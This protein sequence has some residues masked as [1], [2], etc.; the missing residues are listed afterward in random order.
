M[1]KIVVIAGAL[2]A[3]GLM[4]CTASG[5]NIQSEYIGEQAARD[6]ALA[7]SGQT[8]GTFERVDLETDRGMTYYEVE[9]S[10]NGTKYAYDI[11]A[12]TGAVIANEVEQSTTP[13]TTQTTTQSQ[14]PQNQDVQKKQTNNQTTAGS[15]GEDAAKQKALSSAGLKQDQVTFVKTKLDRDDGRTVYEIEFYR[16]DTY[17]EYDYEI[18]A[19]TGDIISQD[20]DAEDYTA[21]SQGQSTVSEQS[22]R[23]TVL[24][25]VP[26]ATDENLQIHLERD[27]GRMSYEGTIIY[28]EMKYD[29]EVDAYSGAV[30]EW[31]AESVYDD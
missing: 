17:A 1:R 31:E 9:F 29:F 12:M 14:T 19:T 18:D 5:K 23:K 13:Q 3:V 25:K 27:D 6:T 30:R 8:Q 28:N 20:Y 21:P 16:N 11:D 2:L 24:A 15:I 26:G 10:A 4:G 7:A 22:V